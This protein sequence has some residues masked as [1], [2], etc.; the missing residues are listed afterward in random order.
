M[1]GR[2]VPRGDSHWELLIKLRNLVEITFSRSIHKDTWIYFKILYKEYLQLLRELF[3]HGSEKPKHHLALHYPRVMRFMGPLCN[4]NSMRFENKH[5]PS[6]IT[7]SVSLSRVNV[8]KTLAIKHQLSMCNRFLKNESYDAGFKCGPVSPVADDLIIEVMKKKLGIDSS[9]LKRVKWV[10]YHGVEIEEGTV[11]MEPKDST[12]KF[13][14]VGAIILKEGRFLIFTK[15]LKTE[16]D[17]H[18]DC[19]EVCQRTN[20]VKIFDFESRMCVIVELG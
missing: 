9:M 15:K 13:F 14:E 1:I 12:I 16:Y 20:N 4:I 2:F 8:Q 7:A 10:N 19:Y 3:P 17:S 18:F 6:K 5:R 11:I